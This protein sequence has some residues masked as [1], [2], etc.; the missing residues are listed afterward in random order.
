M[1]LTPS[2][3]SRSNAVV[4]PGISI[5]SFRGWCS[6]TWLCPPSSH[7]PGMSDTQLLPWSPLTQ[8]HNDALAGPPAL[9]PQPTSWLYSSRRGRAAT[10]QHF[11]RQ[12]LQP[13]PSLL[14]LPL[15]VMWPKVDSFQ[16]LNG[17]PVPSTLRFPNI[18]GYPSL[19]LSKEGALC[20]FSEPQQCLNFL[21]NF[22]LLLNEFSFLW[23]SKARMSFRVF[24][25]VYCT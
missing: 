12:S 25:I 13:S 21:H 3:L 9:S 18:W 15:I 24:P 23:H 17:I 6:D 4:N 8:S 14:Q 10:S 11:S 22:F 5:S 20:L 16:M 19:W 2:S 7:W 1:Y